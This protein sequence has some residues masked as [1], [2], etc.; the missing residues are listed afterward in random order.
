MKY[1][2]FKATMEYKAADIIELISDETGYEF[3]DDFLEEILDE[4]EVVEIYNR[5]G[6]LTITLAE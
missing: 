2:A 6:W 5:G 1:K 3:D 4:M